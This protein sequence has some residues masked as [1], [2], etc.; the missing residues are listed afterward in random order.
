MAIYGAIRRPPRDLIDRS[1]ILLPVA[2]LV[3]Y[4]VLKQVPGH[5]LE[6]I[7]LPL[8]ILSVRG[9]QTFR[10]PAAVGALAAAA[11]VVPGAFFAADVM[12]DQVRGRAQPHYLKADEM[13]ALD[14]LRDDPRPGGV[15]ADSGIA[16]AVPVHS[17]RPVW[18]GHPSWTPDYA[19]RVA[20]ADGVFHEVF[21]RTESEG[22][23][24]ESRARFALAGCGVRKDLRRTAPGAVV[25]VRRFGCAAVYELRAGP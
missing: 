13:R 2:M 18:A 4:A 3:V 11:L 12:R 24:L 21:T 22:V 23:L 9:W 17:G 14:A 15:I 20:E 7:S 1:L 8:A 6:G 25:D 19:T 10:L 16:V 5:A